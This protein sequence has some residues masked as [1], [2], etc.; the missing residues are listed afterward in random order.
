MANL[1][2]NEYDIRFDYKGRSQARYCDAHEY[3]AI[4]LPE[5]L[6]PDDA[7]KVAIMHGYKTRAQAAWFES[8]ASIRETT[9]TNPE[10]YAKETGY[11][12]V[13][14]HPYLD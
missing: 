13:I 4:S 8:Y 6:S 7:L 2:D 5:G 12:L 10:T 9:R 14:T 1:N 11:R 3:Y